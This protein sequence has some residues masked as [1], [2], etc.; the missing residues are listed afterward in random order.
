MDSMRLGNRQF[1]RIR[2]IVRRTLGI[3]QSRA[4]DTLAVERD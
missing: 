1:V 3:D 2:K 4:K